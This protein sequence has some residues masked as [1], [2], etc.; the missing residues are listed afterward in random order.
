MTAK[1]LD[2]NQSLQ[3]ERKH[4]VAT[5][6]ITRGQARCVS[7]VHHAIVL[8]RH[9]DRM[10]TG[11]PS[12]GGTLSIEHVLGTMLVPLYTYHGVPSANSL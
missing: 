1:F 2:P 11:R 5:V 3:S 7:C 10:F 9:T 12:L 8:V 4:G 6:A